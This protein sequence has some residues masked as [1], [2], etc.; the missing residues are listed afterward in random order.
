MQFVR[1]QYKGREGINAKV[2]KDIKFPIDFDAFE[3]CSTEL[4]E[5]LVPMRARFKEMDD[6]ALEKH[7]K[8][9]DLPKRSKDSK[10]DEEKLKAEPYWFEDGN[11]TA[12]IIQCGPKALS[13]V[14]L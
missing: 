12:T 8:S 6:A 2:L 13:F 4:Q 14:L 1:F 11:A 7:A 10:E 9:K 5:K 3:L